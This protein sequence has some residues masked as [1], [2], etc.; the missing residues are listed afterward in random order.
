MQEKQLSDGELLNAIREDDAAAFEMLYDRYWKAL[1]QKACQRVNQDEAKDMVQEVMIT[2]WKRRSH[3]TVKGGEIGAYLFTAIKYRVISHYAFSEA[4]IK[5]TAFFDIL[6]QVQEAH[7]NSLETK[8]LKQLID[9][10]VSQLPARMQQ[11]FRMSR[12]DDYSIA[13]IARQLNLSEQTVKNQLTEALKRLRIALQSHVPG[14][15]AL[16]LCYLF[17]YYNK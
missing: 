12:E 3:V 2:L 11:I 8:E 1:Y 15:W 4:E 13:E 7:P 16:L 14:G 6:D 5:Q 9:N 17:C 10:A